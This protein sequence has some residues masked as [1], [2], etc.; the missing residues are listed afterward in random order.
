[1][2]VRNGS[3]HT[4]KYQQIYEQAILQALESGPKTKNQ[5]N[6]LCPPS[7]LYSGFHVDSWSVRYAIES[8]EKKGDIVCIGKSG[9]MSPYGHSN[10]N[11][12]RL[13]RLQDVY[14]DCLKAAGWIE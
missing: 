11:S 4:E 5:L 9:S 2:V 13:V 7:A 1:M 12:W 6:R 14:V 8:L 3:R 10:Y